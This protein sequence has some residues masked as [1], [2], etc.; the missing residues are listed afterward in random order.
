MAKQKQQKPVQQ[1]QIATT[2]PQRKLALEE[3]K[4]QLEASYQKVLG[5]LE[6][7]DAILLQEEMDA[8]KGS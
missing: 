5:A 8:K 1:E 4:K 7:L 2:N 6:L 3:Q